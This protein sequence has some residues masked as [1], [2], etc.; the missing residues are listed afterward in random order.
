MHRTTLLISMVRGSLCNMLPRVSDLNRSFVPS[1][2]CFPI[3]LPN[4][5]LSPPSHLPDT[6]DRLRSWHGGAWVA[7]AG[8]SK[9]MQSSSLDCWLYLEY[10]FIL[11]L[12]LNGKKEYNADKMYVPLK[13]FAFHGKYM[14]R[15]QFLGYRRI[16]W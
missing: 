2:Q 15:K 14:L 5:T 11:Q 1:S 8:I 3:L 10:K 13:G 7:K 16:A 6:P 9:G 12:S 4:A